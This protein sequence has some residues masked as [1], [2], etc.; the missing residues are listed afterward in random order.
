MTFHPIKCDIVGNLDDFRF[1]YERWERGHSAAGEARD[2]TIGDLGHDDFL[3]GELTDDLA[4]LVDLV[5]SDLKP[6]TDWGQDDYRAVADGIEARWE[7]RP[8]AAAAEAPD[9]VPEGGCPDGCGGCSCHINPPCSHCTDGH[10]TG[11][12]W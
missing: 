10:E 3:I 2:A 4:T 9:T 12:C 1:I 6:L 5:S 11:E 7:P 8:G